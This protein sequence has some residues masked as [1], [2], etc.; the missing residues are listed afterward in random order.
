LD[1]PEAGSFFGTLRVLF[2][3]G[4][5]YST[6]IDAGCADGQFF[7]MLCEMGLAP[8]AVPF[9][10]DANSLYEESLRAIRAVAGGDFSICALTDREGEIEFTMAAHSYWSSLRP[11]DDPYWTAINNLF[12]TKSIVPARTL[13]MLCTQF[14]LKPPFLLKLDVQGAEEQTL[15][16]AAEML[17]NTH[18]VICEALIDDYRA[19]DEVL[20]HHDFA[21]YDVTDV[22]RL[23]DGS[24]GW[25][26]PVYINRAL[27]MVRPRSF[28]DSTLNEVVVHAQ[29]Q[30]RQSVLKMN[31]EIL[32]RMKTGL[33]ARKRSGELSRNYP[34]PCG[35]GKRYKHCCGAY[36]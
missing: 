31:A 9:N 2:N 12:T 8:G 16:G 23:A 26:H 4:V 17:K 33:S 25:F 28:W 24:L 36:R 19:I 32:E 35:S 22:H 14:A 1:N 5:R 7:L 20:V 13:D 34:C 15:S 27:D 21:L 29:V 3:K 10:I 6:V 11:K 18:T 30:R